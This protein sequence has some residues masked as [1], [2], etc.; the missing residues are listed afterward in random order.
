MKTV[1]NRSLKWR[2]WR[3]KRN[4]II[5]AAHRVIRLVLRLPYKAL[6]IYKS[7]GLRLDKHLFGEIKGR[8][9]RKKG[10]LC[11][12]TDLHLCSQKLSGF[13]IGF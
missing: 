6:D 10:T 13:L 3:Q 12:G 7:C 8:R 4:C 11:F 5:C 2:R 1:L 9:N